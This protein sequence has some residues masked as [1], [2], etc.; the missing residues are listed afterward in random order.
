MFYEVWWKK[1]KKNQTNHSNPKLYGLAFDCQQVTK[2]ESQSWDV[3]LDAIITPRLN[4]IYKE[5]NEPL[6]WLRGFGMNLINENSM[7]KSFF[8][9]YATGSQ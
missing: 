2:I 9:K 3:A 5:N 1:F 6:R 8:Q 7:F 4:W